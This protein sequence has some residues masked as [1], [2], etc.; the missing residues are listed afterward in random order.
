MLQ[1]LPSI[2]HNQPIQSA[3]EL[4]CSYTVKLMEYLHLQYSGLV[5]EVH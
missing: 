2:H 3:L 1:L 5:E 4:D